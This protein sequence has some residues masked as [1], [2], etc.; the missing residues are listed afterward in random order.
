MNIDSY[1]IRQVDTGVIFWPEEEEKI[2]T[3]DQTRRNKGTS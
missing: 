3:Q 2:N 1:P